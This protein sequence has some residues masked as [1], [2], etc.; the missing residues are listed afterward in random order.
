MNSICSLNNISPSVP[1]NNSYWVADTAR[2]IGNVVINELVSIW[3]GAIIRGDNE[4]IVV[5]RGSNIQENCVLH[6]DMGYPLIVKSNCT[7]GHA[8]ILHGCRVGV[9]TLIGMGSIVLNGAII[10][11]NCLI[12]AGTLIT[13]GK[14]I[15]DGVLVMGAPGKVIRN[16]KETELDEIKKAA[17]SYQNKI[18]VFDKNLRS[19]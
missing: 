3:F 16:L 17:I 14:I 5:G 18:K 6:T 19:N 9:N 15:P 2:V 13:E 8:A 12:G 4:R 11:D 10:G 7:I 1:N